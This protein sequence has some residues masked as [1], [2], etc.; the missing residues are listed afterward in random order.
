MM[1]SLR[2]L[3]AKLVPCGGYIEGLYCFSKINSETPKGGL[4]KTISHNSRA[5]TADPEFGDLQMNEERSEAFEESPPGDDDDWSHRVLCSDGNCIGVMGPNGRCKECGKPYDGQLPLP[6][7]G[8]PEQPD[9]QP[10]DQ[11]DEKAA[12]DEEVES[13]TADET[14]DPAWENRVLCS[15]GNCIGVIGSNG[16]CKECGKP[17]QQGTDE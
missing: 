3:N 7:Q 14:D 4:P 2:S 5:A 15:D 6:Q 9:I 8:A 10:N 11:P 16:R 17:Y 13:E 1:L 12:G